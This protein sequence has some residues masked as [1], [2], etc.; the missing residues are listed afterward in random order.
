MSYVCK[1]VIV[2]YS[3]SSTL[4]TLPF[5]IS[6]LNYFSCSFKQFASTVRT[7]GH[8]CFLCVYMKSRKHK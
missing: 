5:C 3:Y 1:Q 8:A 7:Y 4:P 6:S 2:F